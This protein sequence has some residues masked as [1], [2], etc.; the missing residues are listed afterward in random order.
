MRYT[1]CIFDALLAII[2]A[3]LLPSKCMT[4]VTTFH[5]IIAICCVEA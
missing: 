3:T 1:A 2:D 5:V 4:A